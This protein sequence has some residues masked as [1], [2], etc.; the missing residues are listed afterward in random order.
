M[1]KT[2]SRLYGRLLQEK[3]MAAFYDPETHFL[4][5]DPDIVPL[6]KSL[7]LRSDFDRE[8][9]NMILSA[10]GWRKVF[11]A[12]GKDE[13]AG[14]HTGAANEAIAAL[15]ADTFAEYIKEKTGRPSPC[16]TVGIDARPTGTEI[17][18][19][20]LR[21]FAAHNLK[22]KYLFITAAPEIMAYSRSAS[23]AFTYISASHNPV[24]HN[25][26]KFG[27]ADGGVIPGTEAAVLIGRFREKTARPDAPEHAARVTASCPPA[28]LE[29]IYRESGAR[30][31]EAV[32]AYAD[33]TREVVSGE[34]GD[35]PESGSRR[36]SFFA[37]IRRETAERPLAVVCDMNGSAR[38]LSIDSPFLQSA[39]I[40][41]FAI[42]DVPRRIAHAIIPEPENLVYCAAE[43]DRLHK[44][45]PEAVLGYMPDC[46]GDRGNIVF[47]NSET[48]KAGVLKAQEVFALSVT[49]ELAYLVYQGAAEP[50]GK[51]KMAVAVNGPTSMRIEEIAAAFG[52][53]VARA[54]VGEANVVNLAR[55]LRDDGYTVRILGEGSNGGNITYPAAVRDPINTLFALIKMLT[56]TD[57]GEKKGIF[58]IWCSLSGRE[59]LYHPGFSLTDIL[60]SLPVYTTTGV[61][62]PR[63]L[64]RIRETDHARLKAR[65]QRIFETQWEEKKETLKA[66]WGIYGWEAVCTNGITETKNP[67]DFSVSGRGGL[68][69]IFTDREC[70]PAAFIWMRGSGTEPVFRVMCDVKG[71][72][73][74][75]ETFLLQWQTDMLT[76]ADSQA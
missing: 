31:A 14:T 23:D 19:I 35:T 17:A 63:A 29:N 68:K 33:F 73:K 7:P 69:I 1:K 2:D 4:L 47:W 61:S 12:S 54:E 70:R 10:S 48:E 34:T 66:D 52:A 57:S 74:A 40:G 36:D 56:L 60:A 20:M 37:G 18:D 53:R 8:V 51:T 24:G 6:S 41:F 39:G 26:V 43:M 22:I 9:S 15:I 55:S 3:N 59:H 71:D 44:T 16:I 64:L 49:A 62:D 46:D 11:A 27:L 42:N 21:V 72:N 13:D 38:T 67:S 28:V 58:H 32:A 45:H 30:K 50:A 5:G 25:G 65:Y 75:M 76:E